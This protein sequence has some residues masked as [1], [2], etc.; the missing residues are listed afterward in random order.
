MKR[1]RAVI[2]LVLTMGLVTGLM[3]VSSGSPAVAASSCVKRTHQPCCPYPAVTEL[4]GVPLASCWSPGDSTQWGAALY[5]CDQLGLMNGVW[6]TPWHD[7]KACMDAYLA[8]NSTD[9]RAMAAHMVSLFIF[10][11]SRQIDPGFWISAFRVALIILARTRLWG[12]W[13]HLILSYGAPVFCGAV[14]LMVSGPYGAAATSI[15][16]SWAAQYI[17]NKEGV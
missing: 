12:T 8:A 14:G 11:R 4:D 17:M 15:G 6:A 1:Y 5:V 3:V 13:A 10:M 2:A 9:G 7:V 16:C